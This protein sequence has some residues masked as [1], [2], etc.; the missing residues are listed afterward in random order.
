MRSPKNKT[1]EDFLALA[2]SLPPLPVSVMATAEVPEQASRE[3]R[4][5][6]E[7]M[8]GGVDNDPARV[9]RVAAWLDELMKRK[10]AK[11]GR[12]RHAR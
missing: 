6:A 8:V 2:R 11:S 9:G 4:R 12:R 3:A 1:R 5:A 10:K 7:L